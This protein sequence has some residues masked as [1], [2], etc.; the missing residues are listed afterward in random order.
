[1]IK[2]IQILFIFTIQFLIADETETQ[3]IYYL[4]P[5]ANLISFNV[6]PDN[7]SVESVFLESS[8]QISTIISEGEISHHINDGWF[9]ALNEINNEN[10][11]W[12]IANDFSIFSI[13]GSVSPPPLYVFVSKSA[14]GKHDVIKISNKLMWK[15]QT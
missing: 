7:S 9:G 8:D 2:T 1:M 3:N 12:I 14:T 13:N 11:Y 5:G 10:G 4:Q 15:F 6:I